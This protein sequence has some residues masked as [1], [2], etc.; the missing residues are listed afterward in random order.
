MDMLMFV[1]MFEYNCKYCAIVGV[2]MLTVSVILTRELYKRRIANDKV[3]KN[4]NI[5]VDIRSF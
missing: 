4:R 3:N 2:L 5:L 1:G